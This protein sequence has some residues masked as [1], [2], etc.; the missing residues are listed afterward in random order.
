M[1]KV[2]FHLCGLPYVL[3]RVNVPT[4]FILHD[5]HVYRHL[6]IIDET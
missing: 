1:F 5:L 3:K 4:N 2:I 6:N